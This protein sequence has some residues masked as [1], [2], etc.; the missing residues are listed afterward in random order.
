MKP[1]ELT[2]SAGKATV[3]QSDNFAQDWFADALHEARSG[4]GHKSRRR[5]IIFAACFAESYIFEWVRRTVQIEE[6]NDYFPPTPRF[7]RDPRYRRSLKEKWKQI[8]HELHKD[9]R[10]PSDPS[11][12][13]SGLGTL[14][15]YR[16]GLVHAAASR[17]ATDV[18]PRKTRPFP[19]KSMLEK[20]KPGWAVVI[21]ADLVRSLHR[22]V[23]TSPPEYV[24][25][26]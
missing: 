7:S 20:V 11:L 15:K 2:A 21:V 19:S 12:D 4:Q 1:A 25:Y 9:G 14:L 8:P 22:A 24:E 16:H 10:I 23:G 17:P 13:L 3:W 18:Q 26:P 6:I 5:E